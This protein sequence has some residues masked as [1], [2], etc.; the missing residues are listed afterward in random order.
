MKSVVLITVDSLRAAHVSSYGHDRETTPRIDELARNGMTY[1][2][3]F[4]QGT[5]TSMSFL[6]SLGGIYP[7][8]NQDWMAAPPHYPRLSDVAPSV[9]DTFKRAGYATGGWH[10]NPL[11][12]R[13]HGYSR[14]FDDFYD[15]IPDGTGADSYVYRKWHDKR[16]RVALVNL[17]K[18]N[19]RLY[20]SLLRSKERFFRMS[21]PF[22]LAD[23]INER[24]LGFID[25]A[26]GPFFG[27][28]HYMD[29]HYPYL[30][31][32]SD[33]RELTGIRVSKGE[34]NR[35]N[36]MIIDKRPSSV[37]PE[38]VEPLEAIYDAALRD[39]D[40][41]IGEFVDRLK[42]SGRWKDTIL[43]LTS[44]HGDQF[45]E[46]GDVGHWNNVW[47]YDELLRVPLIVHGAGQGVDGGLAGLIDI[48]P[49]LAAWCGV[50]PDPDYMGQSLEA[51][52][53]EVFAEGEMGG[54]VRVAVRTSKRKFIWDVSTDTIELFDL[55]TDPGETV[56]ISAESPDGVTLFKEL[57]TSHMDAARRHHV[58]MKARKLGP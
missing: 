10:S 36:R 51:P 20:R 48:P 5:T 49:S 40:I 16:F 6:S 25:N 8:A 41:R 38:K 44:D 22:D 54:E 35:L 37:P 13:Q 46:H 56:D 4:S 3:A 57:A 11:L 53:T 1:T 28:V 34:I 33:V 12:S 9:A 21:P 55:G 24:A 50:E 42:E 18:R 29:L 52:R 7:L 23:S 43:V 58:R 17:L 45:M 30:P 2:N 15:S 26:E 31:I 14:G 39:L 47:Y 27:W 32:P 19:K